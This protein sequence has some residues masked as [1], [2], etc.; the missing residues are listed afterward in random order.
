M[1]SGVI[2]FLCED[3]TTTKRNIAQG[4]HS[5]AH[6]NFLLVSKAAKDLVARMLSTS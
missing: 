6:R 5:L 3:K 4:K 1:L 2:P